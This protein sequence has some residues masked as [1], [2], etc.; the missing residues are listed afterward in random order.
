MLLIYSRKRF[1]RKLFKT[2][3]S[4][5]AV[6]TTEF[7]LDGLL[8]ASEININTIIIVHNSIQNRYLR[9][10]IKF[11]SRP[12]RYQTKFEFPP[13]HCP[14]CVCLGEIFLRLEKRILNV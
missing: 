12:T 6:C 1:S 2:I 11:F 4:R 14:G 7:I 9:V 5:T 10:I 8:T 3:V 13:D